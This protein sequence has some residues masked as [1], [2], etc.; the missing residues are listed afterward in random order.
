MR[1]WKAFYALVVLVWSFLVV[2]NRFLVPLDQTPYFCPEKTFSVVGFFENGTGPEF[3]DSLPTLRSYARLFN[4]VSPFW[5]TVGPDG[6]LVADGYRPEVVAFA[7]SRRLKIVPLVTNEKSGPGNSA[8]AIRT[9]FA[10]AALVDRL[11]S[12]VLDRGYDGLNLDF[13]LLPPERRQD[14]SAFVKELAA[15]LHGK[16]RTL[17]VS[18]FPDVEVANTISGFFDYQ[19]IGQAA[20]FVVLMAY[21]R[22]WSDTA[23]GPVAPEAWV[24]AGLDSLLGHV[25]AEKVL[26]GIGTHAYDWPAAEGGGIAEYL[27]TRVALERAV[28]SGSKVLYDPA[29]RQSFFTYTADTGVPREVWLQDAGNLVDKAEL[30]LRRGLGGV[31]V[32]RLGFSEDGALESLGRALGRRSGP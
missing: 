8:D 25:P 10:R 9:D 29:S 13:E 1:V 16:G 30:A 26:L 11:V 21:D 19:A 24:E 3:P 2:W 22:H 7:R 6:R 20:D 18:V 31:A 17:T 28:E 27:P 14:Y 32:W 23:P 15:S 5:Y 12:V 4:V